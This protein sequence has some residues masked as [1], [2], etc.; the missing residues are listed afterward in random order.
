MLAMA[1]QRYADR[2]YEVIEGNGTL[3]L[4]GSLFIC[5]RKIKGKLH[6]RVPNP[7]KTCISIQVLASL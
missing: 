3:R 5:N 4:Q 7:N 2:K 1:V 6:S